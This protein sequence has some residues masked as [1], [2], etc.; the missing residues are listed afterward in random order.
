M[1]LIGK[2]ALVTG[3]AMGIGKAVVSRFLREGAQVAFSDI[4]EP[5][6]GRR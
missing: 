4:N 5:S 3:G 6:A 1:K 2:V